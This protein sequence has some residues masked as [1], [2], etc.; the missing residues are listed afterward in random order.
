M[1]FPELPVFR[2][3][4][5]TYVEPELEPP[6]ILRGTSW[7]GLKDAVNF[8]K[9][10]SSGKF[11]MRRQSL[12]GSRAIPAPGIRHRSPVSRLVGPWA[13]LS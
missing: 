12:R 11:T 13:L 5:L 1:V 2:R 8:W 3:L 10:G 6:A 7:R 9:A 4:R